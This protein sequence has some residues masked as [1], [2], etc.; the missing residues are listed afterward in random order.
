MNIIEAYNQIK[1]KNIIEEKFESSEESVAN[2]VALALSDA[3]RNRSQTKLI[4]PNDTKV[5]SFTYMGEK[6]KIT[7]TKG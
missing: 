1:N 5:I 2:S 4:M 6:F 3:W 7:V